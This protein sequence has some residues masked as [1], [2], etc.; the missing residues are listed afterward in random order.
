M[1]RID[2]LIILV[3]LVKFQIKTF[4][5]F[6]MNKDIINQRACNKNSF[7]YLNF[8]FKCITL[9]TYKITC[10]ILVLIFTYILLCSFRYIFT[11]SSEILSVSLIWYSIL[12]PSLTASLL[13]P[14]ISSFLS[15]FPPIT[16]LPQ[17]HNKQVREKYWSTNN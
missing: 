14:F 3:R 2:K 6:Q 1:E 5:I 11:H 16:S 10:P 4:N 12:F 15:L 9:Q 17:R 13:S 7:V 8:Y